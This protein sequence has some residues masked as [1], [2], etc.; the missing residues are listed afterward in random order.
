MQRRRAAGFTYLTILFVVALMGVGLA[1]AGETWHSAAV[2]EREAALLHVGEQYRRAIAR[3]YLAGPRQ[4]PRTLEDLLR[5][6]RKPGIERYL[7]R[8]YPDPVTNSDD[9]GIVRA[10]DDGIMGVY[11]RSEAR[12]VKAANFPPAQSGFEGARKYSDWKF[13]YVPV[14]QPTPQKPGA[15]APAAQPGASRGA[16]RINP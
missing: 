16:A 12:P 13:V 14:D 15:T 8:L 4:Y 7:R 11:S 6:Q 2:R 10:F 9:W 5:D 3:Y 1:L